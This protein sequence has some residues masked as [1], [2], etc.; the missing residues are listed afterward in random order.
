MVV[1]RLHERALWPCGG[2]DGQHVHF[3]RHQ[4]LGALQE[5]AVAPMAA[6]TRN[7][8]LAVFGEIGYFSFFWMS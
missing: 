1:H 2:V 5:I 6:P 4:F 3:A 7:R 8:P